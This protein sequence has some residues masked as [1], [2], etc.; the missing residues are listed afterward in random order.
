MTTQYIH[1]YLLTFYKNYKYQLILIS[2]LSIYLLW[3]I[4]RTVRQLFIMR[5]VHNKNW[6]RAEKKLFYGYFYAQSK[7]KIK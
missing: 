7:K 5:H 6:T 2:F 4:S 3:C 1:R